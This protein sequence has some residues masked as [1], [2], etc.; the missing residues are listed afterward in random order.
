MV[1]PWSTARSFCPSACARCPP[2][3]VIATS[4][5]N[6]PYVRI[7]DD[8]GFMVNSYGSAFPFPGA[9][10]ILSQS[11]ALRGRGGRRRAHLPQDLAAVS[12][13]CGAGGR[14]GTAPPLRC[15]RGG[16][17]S[18]GAD[19]LSDGGAED[20]RV[21]RPRE[22][23]KSNAPT[24]APLGMPQTAASAY[25]F[26]PLVQRRVVPPI[27]PGMLPMTAPQTPPHQNPL[28]IGPQSTPISANEKG[29]YAPKS[30]PIIAPTRAPP[31]APAT[32]PRSTRASGAVFAWRNADNR[33]RQ[34]RLMGI[35]LSI[36]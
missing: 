1:G 4:A 10:L 35:T 23:Q 33:S 26:G 30:T 6:G 17:C 24:A 3:R 13:R 21:R 16:E 27:I 36:R 5:I 14:C 9:V 18:D 2:Q 19:A 11:P 34:R 25:L 31:A 20:H 12:V 28:R 7:E 8:C 22:R 15:S 32:P 29:R